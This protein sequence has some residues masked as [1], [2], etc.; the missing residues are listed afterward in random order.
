M[1]DH[2]TSHAS[3]PNLPYVFG[4]IGGGLSVGFG[5]LS[6]WYSFGAPVGPMANHL[7]EVGFTGIDNLTLL[8]AGNYSIGF[9][10]LG[11]VTMIALNAVAWR[12]TGG[13]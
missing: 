3:D 13:Y 7:G 9:I 2:G 8:P 4:L 12:R 1:S 11:A 10:V 6:L 5:I